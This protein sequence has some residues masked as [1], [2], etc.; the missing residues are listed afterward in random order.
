MKRILLDENLPRP[1]A[2]LFTAP[3]EVVSVHDLGWAE[4]KNG[5]LIRSML[6]EGL[7]FL[8]TADKNLQNQQNLEK[9]PV[10]LIVLKTFD[11]RFKTLVSYVSV[12]QE[13]IINADDA[14]IIEIDIRNLK[15]E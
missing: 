3:L 7:E 11:N 12:I 8:L 1:L 4:K 9:Y 14:Q 5:D 2:K 13:A 6:E 10:R 15:I